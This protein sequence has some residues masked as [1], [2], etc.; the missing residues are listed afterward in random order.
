M[1]PHLSMPFLLPEPFISG[2]CFYKEITS[3]L[4]SF[5]LA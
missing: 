3:L 2:S 4:A 1:H 5:R